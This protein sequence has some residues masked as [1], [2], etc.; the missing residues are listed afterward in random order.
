MS[1][2]IIHIQVTWA[3]KSQK[4]KKTTKSAFHKLI[5]TFQS[6]VSWCIIHT[7]VLNMDSVATK[8]KKQ[9]HGFT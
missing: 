9:I 7:H 4:L 5:Q 3:A 1:L 6:T 2:H 8:L